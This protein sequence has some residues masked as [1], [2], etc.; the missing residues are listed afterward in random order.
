M[1]RSA[2]VS[3]GIVRRWRYRGAP[4]RPDARAPDFTSLL[5]DALRSAPGE[6]VELRLTWTSGTDGSIALEARGRTA[7]DW[8][9]ATVLLAFPPAS[10]VGV[11]GP[12]PLPPPLWA[13]AKARYPLERPFRECREDASPRWSDPVVAALFA[14]PRGVAVDW[15][16]RS[17]E[18]AEPH[19]TSPAIYASPTGTRTLPVP[20]SS[21]ELEDRRAR[22]LRE[23]RWGLRGSLRSADDEVAG[24]VARLVRSA[25]REDGGNGIGWRSPGRL[26]G[27]TPAE[28]PLT[29]AELV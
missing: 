25:S 16:L 6:G 22:R 20:R 3:S 27:R 26:L 17:G 8:V 24:W 5:D 2:P 28:I 14:L 13:T 1:R 9:E 4:V 18:T 12:A 21:L 10:W 29:T 19:E 7:V 15:E 23:L 11:P